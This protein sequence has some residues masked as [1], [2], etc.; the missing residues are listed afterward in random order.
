MVQRNA[1]S[2]QKADQFLQAFQGQPEHHLSERA[3]R[4]R[5]LGRACIAQI[6]SDEVAALALLCTFGCIG[7]ATDAGQFRFTQAP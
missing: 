3:G 7:P 6:I 1:R 2:R 4:R 5:D